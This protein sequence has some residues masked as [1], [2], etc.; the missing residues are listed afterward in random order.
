V[1]LQGVE[2]AKEN[3]FGN[4]NKNNELIKKDLIELK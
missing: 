2:L 3:G 1:Q 4:V